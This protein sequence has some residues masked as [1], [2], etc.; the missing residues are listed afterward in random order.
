MLI[1][2]PIPPPNCSAM[3][4]RQ[5]MFQGNF[6]TLE[7]TQTGWSIALVDGSGNSNALSGLP[8]ASLELML[9][10]GTRTLLSSKK[11]ITCERGASGQ[12]RGRGQRVK[13]L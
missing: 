3:K 7:I 5:L 1:K 2:N 12:I 10:N 8:T 11:I 9:E 13:I 6:L 4:L